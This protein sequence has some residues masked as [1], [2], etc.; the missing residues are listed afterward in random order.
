M[1]LPAACGLLG[2][3][4]LSGSEQPA[5]R[6]KSTAAGPRTLEG[7][8]EKAVIRDYLKSW[9]GLRAALKRQNSAITGLPI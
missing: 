7:Q 4:L 9:H 2:T 3:L 5:V 1:L 6:V 8:T